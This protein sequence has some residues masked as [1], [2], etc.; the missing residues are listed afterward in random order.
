[1][2]RFHSLRSRLLIVTA[3][4]FIVGLAAVTL[5][6]STLMSVSSR[7]EAADAA[8]GLLREYANAIRTDIQHAADISRN[9]ATTAQVLAASEVKDRDQLGR[10]VTGMVADNPDVL[11][12]TLVFEP[13]ALDGRDA[14]FVGHPFSDAVGGR[15]ATY[16]YRDSAKQIAV[17][18]LDMSDPAARV[19][20][21]TPRK[22]GRTV[23]TPSYIDDIDGVPTLLTTVGSPIRVNGEIIGTTGVDFALAEVS[24]MIAKLKPFGVGNVSLIDGSGQWLAN[25]DAG[26]LGKPVEDQAVTTLGEAA[27][28]DG[29]S[30]RVIDGNVYQAAI[31]V[32]FPGIEQTWL[33]VLSA[34]ESAMVEG[35]TTA[36]NRMLLI[37]AGI[38]AAALV[39]AFFVATNFGRP[40]ERITDVMRRLADGDFA[41]G[42]PFVGRRDEIGGMAR[43][44]EIF[45]Q[46]AAR[47][48]QLEAEAA[49][50]RQEAELRR[51]E[52]QRRVEAEAEERLR[53]ATASLADGLHRLSSGDM[54]C[55][56]DTPFAEQFETLRHDFN[57]SARRLREVLADVATSVAI[58]N[59][60]AQEISAASNNLTQRAEQQAASLEQTASAL[61]E[62]TVN[63]RSTTARTGD[64]RGTVH[65]ARA[66]ADQSGGVV[67]ETI[68]AMGR[69][70][71]SSQRIG[72]IID[73]I[74]EIAFQT[75][76]LALNAGVE[77]A[78]A[79]EAGKGFAVVA[80]EV[81]A[82]A[83]RSSDAAKEIQELVNAAAVAVGEGVKLVGETGACLG[84]ITQLVVSA[85]THMEAIATA[86]HEQA[87]GVS[88]VN[89]SVNHM[90][91][92]TQQNVAMAGQMS[93]AGAA[94]AME[95]VKL[96]ELLSHF[97]FGQQVSAPG[98]TTARRSAAA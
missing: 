59:T 36:R 23:I 60:G 90:D 63:V 41:I 92:G 43:S 25:A 58:V 35:A 8:R 48:H 70:E 69:I 42:V 12:V 51:T 54:L 27:R 91:Q 29:I 95:S 26:L 64:A 24:K 49:T 76:L 31:P 17:E 13:Q 45:R 75:N 28:R 71:H 67:S 11:G 94:L 40:I 55:E 1:M 89:T 34:P 98:Q 50:S 3:I 39:G 21:D 14:D 84:E 96:A 5:A 7:T 9:L 85:N 20:Y 56:I 52:M 72:Q 93:A 18:K 62:I 47:N 2:T 77:A 66:K 46:A 81:R 53:L 79:G 86:A 32:V 33:L 38:L 4:G 22:A 30:E 65:E 19:W 83:Q 44:V 37:S 73:V 16:I 57:M 61:E 80:Q 97:R 6:G 87:I 88:E 10:A 68:A 78:R 74:Q 82:L 15:F